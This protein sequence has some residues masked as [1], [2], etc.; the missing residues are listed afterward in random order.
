MK[1]SYFYSGDLRLSY[2]D[3]GGDGKPVLLLLHGHFGN[4]RTFTK[5]AESLKDWHVYALDQRGHGW[6]DHADSDHYTREDYIHDI[7]QFSSQVIVEDNQMVILGHSLG[8]VNAYQF[9]ARNGYKVRSLIIEDIGAEINDDLSFA[10]FFLDTAPTL[11]ALSDIIRSFGIEDPRYFLESAYEDETGWH[12]R[13]DKNNLPVS[14]E[15]LNGNWWDDLLATDC[16]MLL[17]HGKHSHV[18]NADHIREIADKRPNTTY[19]IFDNSGHGIHYDETEHFIEV[20]S[21]FLRDMTKGY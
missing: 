10:S 5:V 14:Q 17:L 2:L 19:Y 15:S 6:S 3:Y 20:V 13:F 16:P 9:T 18:T 7:E 21:D 1:R 4:A 8:G 12:F 11:E